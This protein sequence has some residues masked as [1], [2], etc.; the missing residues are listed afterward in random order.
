MVDIDLRQLGL[1]GKV[2]VHDCWKKADAGVFYKQYS[3]MVAAH[4]AV[5][6]RL[7]E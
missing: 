4:G 5:L 3:Q 6:I 1:K 7:G 2:A